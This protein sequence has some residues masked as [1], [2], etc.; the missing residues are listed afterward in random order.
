M[1]TVYRRSAGGLVAA[2]DPAAALTDGSA[3]WV[4]LLRPTQEEAKLVEDAF[5]IDAPTEDERAM[6]EYS[7]RFYEENGALVL[8]ATLVSRGKEDNP[9]SGGVSFILTGKETLI[10]VRTIDPFAFRVGQGR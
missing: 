1:L 5:G 2:S 9:Q 7:A 6:L 4:D 10:T 3:I 8:T